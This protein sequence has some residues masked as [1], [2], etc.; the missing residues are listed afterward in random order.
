MKN[1]KQKLN[2]YGLQQRGLR[3]VEVDHMPVAVATDL[4]CD[5]ARRQTNS[6]RKALHAARQAFFV[7]TGQ[8]IP[9]EVKLAKKLRG[10]PLQQLGKWLNR[11]NPK[12]AELQARYSALLVLQ[13]DSERTLTPNPII[14]R[15]LALVNLR[16]GQLDR[17]I[18]LCENELTYRRNMTRGL[19]VP[20]N[21]LIF[22][23][24]LRRV[25]CWVTPV[26]SRKLPGRWVRVFRVS[27]GHPSPSYAARL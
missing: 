8:R 12:R 17:F 26:V 4:L 19:T 7:S 6:E 11:A 9:A 13:A 27:S 18:D 16:A 2:A 14:E 3:R 25:F 24:A 22:D 5:P 20:T 23:P 10:K 1:A 15:N 21:S